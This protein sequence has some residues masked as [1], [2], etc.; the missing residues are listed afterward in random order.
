ML[1]AIKELL[2]YNCE[3]YE[4]TELLKFM[5]NLCLIESDCS[6][7]LRQIT[8]PDIDLQALEYLSFGGGPRYHGAYD[9]SSFKAQN[10]KHVVFSSAEFWHEYNDAVS[11]RILRSALSSSNVP[12]L[13]TIAFRNYWYS[14]SYI[15]PGPRPDQNHHGPGRC[16]GLQVYGRIAKWLDWFCGDE[17]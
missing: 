8:A 12:A 17:I 5:P 7:S 6:L 13:E 3:V 14:R 1:P 11:T 16:D 2:L 15:I 4:G 10:I 9:I